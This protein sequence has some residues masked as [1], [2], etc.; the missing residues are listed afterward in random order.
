MGT[1]H[2]TQVA[3]GC[4]EAQEELAYTPRL[5]EKLLKNYLDIRYTL[6]GKSPDLPDTYAV[7]VKQTYQR[8]PFGMQP[9]EAPWPFMEKLHAT[10]PRDGKKQAREMLELHMSCLDI[11]RALKLLDDDD[12]KLIYQYFIFQTHTLD[13][14]VAERGLTSRG[15][16]Q[17]RTQ[18]VLKKLTRI[19]N[20]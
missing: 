18:R 4:K 7:N 3:L 6:E 8:V 10:S 1:I 11:E 14:L 16:M 15:S 19:M 20:G 5:V 13:E 17:S 2:E 12:L 9:S